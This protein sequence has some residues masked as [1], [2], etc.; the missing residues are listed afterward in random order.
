M[1]ESD[2]SVDMVEAM[3]FDQLI[4]DLMG[5]DGGA[6]TNNGGED[7]LEFGSSIDPGSILNSL[8]DEDDESESSA[9][10]NSALRGSKKTKG[11]R[12]RTL[13]SE[14]KR[15]GRMKDKLYAL[16]ALVPNITKMDKASIVGDA[17][18]YVQ[19]LQTQAKQLKAEISDLQSLKDQTGHPNAIH[20]V[21]NKTD[22]IARVVAPTPKTI[23]QMEVFRVE[24]REFYVRLQS[25]KA[26]GVAVCLY[27]A[28]ESLS[29]FAVRS[30]NLT[31]VGD[32]FVFTFTSS[33]EDC[34]EHCDASSLKMCI[35]RALKSGKKEKRSCRKME[36]GWAE[37]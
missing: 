3:N 33:A 31:T 12:S 2:Y 24:E 18:L 21:K 27:R 1:E 19:Q 28:L 25:N 9:T 7:R 6:A 13:V 23:T 5:G 35:A 10:K 29:H 4:V 26:G 17:V 36:E 32:A 20:H 34:Q 8:S 22:S 37:T 16:R 14:R 30:S 15:R 11:D